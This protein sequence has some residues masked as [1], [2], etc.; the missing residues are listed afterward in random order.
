MPLPFYFEHYKCLTSWLQ[1]VLRVTFQDAV[2]TLLL[3][4]ISASNEKSEV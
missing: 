3:V 2:K 1:F 4:L